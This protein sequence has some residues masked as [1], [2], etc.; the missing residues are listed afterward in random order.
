M[1]DQDLVA[2]ATRVLKIEGVSDVIEH[3][4]KE[5]VRRES[6]RVMAEAIG[7]PEPAA[8]AS[9]VTSLTSRRRSA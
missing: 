6:L 8:A 4:L 1:L 9:T 7:P 5:S 2:R 3:A